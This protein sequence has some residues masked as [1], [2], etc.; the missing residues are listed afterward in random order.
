MQKRTLGRSGMEVSSLAFA[1]NVFVWTADEST[2]M[3][4]LDRF[5]NEGFNFIDT[6]ETYSRWV[7]GN[8][9]GES[10]TISCT[11][12]IHHSPHYG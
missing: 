2:S 11:T 6:A 8:K 9:G 7:P 1:G 4:L 12:S 10:E 5:V 3:C